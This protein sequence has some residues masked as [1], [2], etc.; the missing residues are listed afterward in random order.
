MDRAAG[1]SAPPDGR[2]Q[3]NGYATSRMWAARVPRSGPPPRHRDR[4][5]PVADS[6]SASILSLV[7]G[8]TDLVLSSGAVGNPPLAELIDAAH[9]GQFAGLTLW[10]ASYHPR[11]AS[12][13][14]LPEAARRLADSGLE[15]QDVDA[16]V[17]WAGAN[18][19][20]GPYFE[21]APERDVLELASAV[22]ARGV[23]LIVT[24]A[25][26]TPLETVVT[27][28]AAACDRAADHGLRV[29]LEFS[30]S[31]TPPDLLGA[32]R[33]VAQAGRPN[34]GIMLDA[35][36]VH[37]G[38]GSF[39]D[40][41]GVPGAHVGG[42]QLSDAPAREPDDYAHATRH[43]RLLPGRGTADLVTLLSELD[44][45]G[46]P[47]PLSVEVFDTH[48]V[49]RVGARSFACELGEATRALLRDSGR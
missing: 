4:R 44:R 15:V 1:E 30:R 13:E 32:S 26:G 31:R 43:A 16:A 6:E 25:S 45:I 42:V 14:P 37:W 39:A 33:V 17:V 11:Q 48:H 23:N 47:A 24:G 9:A 46:S 10:P 8:P 49:E 35:W 27:A 41:A 28:F 40:L 36:H 3:C 5:P 34:G 21:E 20:G 2:R 7:L 22:A 18:D 38:P 19:P 12:A 29:H